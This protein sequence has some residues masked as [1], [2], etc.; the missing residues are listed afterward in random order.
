M[1]KVTILTL[2]CSFLA[3]SEAKEL[4]VK[5]ERN[6]PVPMRDGT[7][8]RADVHRPD[9]GGP[10]PVLVQRTP[11]GKRGSFGRF[12][13]A[14]YIVVSQDA[15]GRD[16]SDGKWESFFRFE[17]HDAEDGYDTIEWAAK[18][19]GSTGKIGTFGISYEAF[20]QWRLAPLRPPSLVS[21][22]ARSMTTRV[23]D[24]HP[25]MICPA[26]WLKWWPQMAVDMRRRAG[27]PGVHRL[28]ETMRL[29]NSGE[30]DKWLDW[31][32]W[33]ELPREVFEDETEAVK[34]W[35]KNTHLDPLRLDEGCKNISVPNLD[36][37][38]WYD[39]CNSDMLLFRTMGKEAKTEVARKGSRIII[40]PWI[41]ARRLQIRRH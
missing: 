17:T 21:M 34:Y 6:V 27:K 1:V 7:I 32:P 37:V 38:G 10:Y 36:I 18:L 28:W 14:G 24:D 20:L 11:Y 33:L 23:T 12:V 35:L 30:F 13:K 31:L 41:H 26:R 19:P 5:I 25:G 16:E 8:L 29:L 2:F 3:G 4:G 15:R 39:Y 22:S 40:G 9:R